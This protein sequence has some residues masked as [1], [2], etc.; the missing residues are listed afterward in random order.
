MF[1][2]EQRAPGNWQNECFAISVW[3]NVEQSAVGIELR[4]PDAAAIRTVNNHDAG[5]RIVG[6]LADDV[7]GNFKR[8]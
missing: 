4:Y 6:I 1:S 8:L 3:V 7:F 2:L 5:R